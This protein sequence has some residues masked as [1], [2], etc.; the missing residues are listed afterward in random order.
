MAWWED[1]LGINPRSRV[2]QTL[3]GVPSPMDLGTTAA[4]GLEYLYD[5]FGP[6]SVA[7]KGLGELGDLIYQDAPSTLNPAAVRAELQRKRQASQPPPEQDV[8]IE[9]IVPD[10]GGRYPEMT[11]PDMAALGRAAGI[12]QSGYGGGGGHVRATING[13]EYDY[14]TSATNPNAYASMGSRPRAPQLGQEGV[15]PGQVRLGQEVGFSAAGEPTME[16]RTANRVS[17]PGVSFIQGT[18]EQQQALRYED[19]QR[20]NAIAEQQ[21]QL[22]YNQLSPGDK[23]RIIAQQKAAADPRF[24]MMSQLQSIIQNIVLPAVQEEE[25]AYRQAHPNAT[26]QEISMVRRQAASTVFNAASKASQS[27]FGR[28]DPYGLE[29]PEF[30]PGEQQ[31][32]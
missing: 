9:A 25:A 24:A 14:T 2:G 20:Q 8:A 6:M 18:P 21:Q 11:T 10:A 31:Q 17:D 26:P 7:R 28:T 16:Y 13:K 27:I 30:G 5:E 1:Q 15:A 12:D 3:A 19:L 22:E 4:T 23:A 32:Q 29:F